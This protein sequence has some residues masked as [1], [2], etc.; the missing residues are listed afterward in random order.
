M[1]VTEK[2][3]QIKNISKNSV[4]TTALILVLI[5][6]VS[7]TMIG[8]VVPKNITLVDDGVEKSI[9]TS[10]IYVEEVL[11]EQ[12]I[13]LRFGDKISL[14]LD[15][16]L[17]SGDAIAIERA[18]KIN[19]TVDG[20]KRELYSSKSIVSEVLAENGI[21]LNE[22]DE[23]TPYLETPLSE[24][25]EVQIFR[26]N[27]MEETKTEEIPFKTIT[28][29]NSSYP[30]GREVVLA[31]GESGSESVTYK[32]ITRDGAEISREVLSR[33]VIK[34][35]TDRIVDKGTF[36]KQATTKATSTPAKETSAKGATSD[37]PSPVS[38]PGLSYKKVIDCTA[39]AYTAAKGAKTASGKVAAV[40]I[41][42]VDPKVI[43]MGTKLYIESADGSWVYG[44]AVAGDIGGAIKGNKVDLFYNTASE[45]YSFGRRTVRVYVLD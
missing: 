12:G 44:H 31:K 4:L 28:R 5:A 2:L 30:V 34:K 13:S 40:G 29:S 21:T 35:A 11:A 14:P 9:S 18:K 19:V 23:I 20:T 16:V 36:K 3:K 42:A 38:A 10:R 41:V 45:C 27:V 6:A 25:L 33:K 7:I 8:F 32:V 24:G 15:A 37:K 1:N 26:V 17:A 43:P 39:T 22:Y